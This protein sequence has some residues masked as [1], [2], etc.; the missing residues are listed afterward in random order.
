MMLKVPRNIRPI[1][2]VVVLASGRRPGCG[3]SGFA[4]G[5]TPLRL[6]TNRVSPSGVTR[7]ESG[8]QPTGMN[9]SDRLW[10]GLVTSNT[11]TVLLLASATNN[12]LSSGDSARLFGVDPGGDCGYRAAQ[13]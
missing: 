12:V 10:P 5:I 13:I 3:P 7:T 1:Y 11:A 9:P 8:Y 6:A 2:S 4:R